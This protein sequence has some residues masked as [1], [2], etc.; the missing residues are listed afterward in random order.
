MKKLEV[1]H[2][3]IADSDDYSHMMDAAIHNTLAP[4]WK[5]SEEHGASIS[6]RKTTD[7]CF[8]SY[9]LKLKVIAQFDHDEDYAIFKLSFSEFPY[10]RFTIN[11][12]MQPIFY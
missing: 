10:R 2:C 4:L 6:F 11:N 1:I 7:N 8:E 3:S 12:L 9:S 5:W